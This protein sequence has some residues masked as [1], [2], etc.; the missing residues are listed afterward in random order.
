MGAKKK[1]IK[2][3]ANLNNSANTTAKAEAKRPDKKDNEDDNWEEEQVVAPTMKVEVAGKLT[4]EEKKE[5]DDTEGKVAW[6]K[7]TSE[8]TLN[9]KDQRKYPSLAKS[10]Q[11]TSA[12]AA[13]NAIGDDHKGIETSK[14]AFAAIAQNRN[15]QSD[16]DE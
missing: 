12:V 8:V 5:E 10:M 3:A 4:H 2:P 6:N 14:N 7:K 11:H 9:E 1:K 16:S 13:H 15:A